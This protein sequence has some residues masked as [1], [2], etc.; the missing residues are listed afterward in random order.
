MSR[1]KI[2]ITYSTLATPNPLVDQYYDEAVEKAKAEMGG[3]YPLYING[4]WVS[5][6]ETFTK[7]SPIDTSLVVGQFALGKK[8]Q[9]DRA[10]AAARAAFP[11]WRDTPWQE[12]VALL[13]KVADLISDRLFEI[14]AVLS[15]EV[16]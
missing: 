14:G 10:V 8:E 11:G 13:R 3:E 9:V 16:V 4:E 1:E 12:R 2:K 6:E 5:T 15:I 7:I